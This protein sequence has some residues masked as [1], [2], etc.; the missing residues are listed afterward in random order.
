MIEDIIIKFKLLYSIWLLK[1][2][3][4]TYM[5]KYTG[6]SQGTNRGIMQCLIFKKKNRVESIG[7]YAS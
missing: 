6:A 2:K 4:S 7:H 5:P 1:M 3:S